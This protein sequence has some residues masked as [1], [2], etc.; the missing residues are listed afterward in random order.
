M[1][2]TLVIKNEGPGGKFCK[3]RKKPGSLL[4]HSLDNFPF[5]YFPE[6]G[7]DYRKFLTDAF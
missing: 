6:L 2:G 3:T 1:T 7:N 4:N 5:K